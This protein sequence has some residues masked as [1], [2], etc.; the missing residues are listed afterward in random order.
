MRRDHILSSGFM[1]K[2]AKSIESETTSRNKMLM[3]QH[4]VVLLWAKDP[5][6]SLFE[7]GLSLT[8]MV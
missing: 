5:T 8:P 2:N 1:K 7:I 4:M 6:P 3:W